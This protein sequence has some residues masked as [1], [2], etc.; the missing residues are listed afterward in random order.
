MTAVF[1]N[2]DDLIVVDQDWIERIKQSAR[3]EPL[4]RA[5][6]N[7]HQSDDDQV[8]EMLIAFCHDSLNAPHRHIGKSESLHAIEGRALIIFFDED[9]SIKRRITI[10]SAG[11][12]LPPWYRL[13]S[14]EW[15]TVIPLDDMVVIHETTT[16]PFRPSKDVV[17]AWIPTDA[18]SL[19][20][21]IEALTPP[22]NTMQNEVLSSC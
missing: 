2:Q 14:S 6:L 15:H 1:K 10:G 7:L 4:R 17:P 18:V 22:S 20:K 8:Q 12:R 5:R 3:E 21:F 16:G 9:G 13:S 11:S 19:R